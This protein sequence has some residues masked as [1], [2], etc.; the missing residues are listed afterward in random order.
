MVATQPVSPGPPFLP[1]S[2]TSPRLNLFSLAAQIQA[3]CA[4]LHA[5]VD[6]I[7][8]YHRINSATPHEVPCLTPYPLR[9]PPTPCES[10]PAMP[11]P[12]FLYDTNPP[13]RSA[14]DP[15]IKSASAV[16]VPHL[17][18]MVIPPPLPPPIRSP[19]P[20][21]TVNPPP[22]LPALTQPAR[23]HHPS[24]HS[25]AS[26]PDSC[27]ARPCPVASTDRI[28]TSADPGGSVAV[29]VVLAMTLRRKP[30]ILVS[31]LPKLRDNP[32][33]QGQEKVPVFVWII[34]QATERFEEVYP[35]LKELAL[36]GSPGTKST[37]QASQQ[38][39]PYTV[40]AMQE[41]M[42]EAI[43]LDRPFEILL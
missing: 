29:F 24:G 32:I 22:P 38:I 41:S 17:S 7:L 14:V 19:A 11:S 1:S 2:D 42:S 37:K 35:T 39:L 13:L 34:A 30:D 6:R 4:S 43:L 23:S 26:S 25:T 15:P 28:A 27:F 20:S 36:A 40:K 8:V 12:T 5:K 21:P 33:Y 3:T 18:M 31:L 9:L 10:L 16:A